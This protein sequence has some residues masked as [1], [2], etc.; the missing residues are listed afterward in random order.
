MGGKIDKKTDPAVK[1]SKDYMFAITT[2]ITTRKNK[3]TLYRK[4]KY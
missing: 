1:S 2:A 3:T 4:E